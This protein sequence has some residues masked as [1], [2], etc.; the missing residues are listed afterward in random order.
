MLKPALVYKEELLK[1]FSEEMYTKRYFYYCGYPSEYEL[2]KIEAS[3]NF[4]QYAILSNDDNRVIGYFGYREDI[5]AS[6]IY[7]F[8]LFSFE[9]GNA[10]VIMDVYNE[11][12]KLLK[13]FHRMEWRCIGGN[14]ALKGYRSF[15]KKHDGVEHIMRDA[16]KDAEGNYLNCH[17]F[18]IIS[19]Y[20]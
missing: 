13:I 2:P 19:P 18:E 4:R 20:K 12:E 1:K 17:I 6:C 7:N 15:C 11:L 10:Q 3:P 14:H 5:Y 9:E 8:G 16:T